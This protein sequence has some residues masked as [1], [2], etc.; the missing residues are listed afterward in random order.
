MFYS[1]FNNLGSVLSFYCIIL[2]M[3]EM[4]ALSQYEIHKDYKFIKYII[5]AYW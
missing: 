2:Y 5:N 3:T 1:E 4:F